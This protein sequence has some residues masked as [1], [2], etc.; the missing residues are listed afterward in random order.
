MDLAGC[1]PGRASV[2]QVPQQFLHRVVSVPG[3]VPQRS[4]SPGVKVSVNGASRNCT[5]VTMR[6]SQ[7]V[8]ANNN[9]L[10]IAW[11]PAR[12]TVPNHMV[13]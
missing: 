7:V 1:V 13:L 10:P 6:A 8:V 5:M 3:R 2:W 4:Q 9:P 11:I 12:A